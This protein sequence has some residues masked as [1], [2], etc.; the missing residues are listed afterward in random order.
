M[1]TRSSVFLG[2]L[3][4]AVVP[5]VH[6]QQAKIPLR[7]LAPPM[8]RSTENFGT[9]LNIRQLP[10]G[11]ILLNDA[12][13][14]RVL[15]LDSTLSSSRVI[16][17]SASGAPNSYGPSRA[18]IIPYLGDSTLFVDNSSQSLLVIDPNGKVA[19]VMAA[20]NPQDLMSLGGAQSYVDNKG[21]LLYRGFGMPKR[22]T[23][24]SSGMPSIPTLP[25]S[26]PILRADFDTRTTDTVGR[27]KSQSGA[28]TTMSQVNGQM[29]G[30]RTVNPVPQVDEWGVTSDGA[31]A[32]V[33]GNDYHIDWVNSDDSHTSSPKLPFDWRRLTDDDKQKLIDSAKA[34]QAD[35]DVKIAE[36]IK[37]G[38]SV[39][40]AAGAAGAVTEMKMVVTEGFVRSA[41]GGGGGAPMTMNMPKV[42]TE[43]V[44]LN[45][46][47]DYYP[48]IRQG[49]VR[50]D[51]DGNLWILPTTS[52][53]SQKGELVYDMIN[54]KGDLTQRVRLP[55]GRSIAGFGKG[56]IVY[57]MYQDNGR[58]F[59][60]KTRILEG[61]GVT[62]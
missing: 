45:E 24:G 13:S 58:W 59:V 23:M 16:I 41:G 26:N 39:A 51:L 25:D 30:K 28:R 37:N 21:R 46:I 34:A 52:A 60:E 22:V 29:V 32:F 2:V 17:D 8:A 54:R 20:P 42:E 48:P 6:A 50:P 49:S 7:E 53:Q 43:Y 61:K 62:Q 56:G 40:G 18:P 10:G 19:R 36:A 5:A 55:V 11:R 57:L 3:T 44:P 4:A 31:V 33:R 38:G 14:R 27:V 9:V 47:P 1:L 12:I 15:M 35:Q